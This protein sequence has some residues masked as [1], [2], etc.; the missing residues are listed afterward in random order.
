MWLKILLATRT[1]QFYIKH[2]HIETREAATAN[3]ESKSQVFLNAEDN[4]REDLVGERTESMQLTRLTPMQVARKISYPLF[5]A[6]FVYLCS[7]MAYPMYNA[8]SLGTTTTFSKYIFQI[9][10][11]TGF[12]GRQ[13]SAFRKGR[14]LRTSQSFFVVALLQNVG[15]FVLFLLVILLRWDLSPYL[16]VPLFCLWGAVKAYYGSVP[17]AMAVEAVKNDDDKAMAVSLLNIVSISCLYFASVFTFT[18]IP[19]EPVAS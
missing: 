1:G 17:Y 2:T 8:F 10:A 12:V 13:A 5:T 18:V 9:D 4:S 19:D 11:L 14:V 6:F 15:L 16:F 3:L 7:Y